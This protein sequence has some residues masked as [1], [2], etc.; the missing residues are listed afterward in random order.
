MATKHRRGFFIA[1]LL[2]L[3][4]VMARKPLRRAQT[5]KRQHRQ[6]RRSVES[7]LLLLTCLNAMVMM[8]PG[9]KGERESYQRPKALMEST[10]H[11]HFS[12]ESV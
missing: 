11:A 12:I 2:I 9:E 3:G 10:D 1:F 7:V 4:V 8:E 6:S 5:R